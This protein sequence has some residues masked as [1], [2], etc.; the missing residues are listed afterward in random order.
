LR[1]VAAVVAEAL[2]A[3]HGSVAARPEGN[4]GVFAAGG[5]NGRVHFP[6]RTAAVSFFPGAPAFGTPAGFVGE[7]LF[8]E[9]FLLGGGKDEVGSAIATGKSFVFVHEKSSSNFCTQNSE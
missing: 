5:A 8:G 7:P 4:H 9:K 6:L 3:V 2:A 1:L